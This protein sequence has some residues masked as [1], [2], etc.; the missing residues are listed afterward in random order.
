MTVLGPR[1]TSRPSWLPA[2]AAHLSD[3]DAL[4]HLVPDLADHE[5]YVCGNPQW[6]ELVADA[7]RAGGVADAYIH[8]ERFTY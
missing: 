6:M 2:S 8:L 3:V 5:V 4:R 7:A 1:A